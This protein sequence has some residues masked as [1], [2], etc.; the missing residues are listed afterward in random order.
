MTARLLSVNLAVP[1]MLRSPGGRLVPSGIFKVPAD[2]PVA[3]SRES[4]EGDV[5]VDRRYHGGPEQAVYAYASE[6]AAHWSRELETADPLPP[7]FFGENFTTEN[8][9]EDGVAIGDVY[10]VG[11]A[12]VAVTRPRSPCF[13]LGLRVGSP[14][15]LRTFLGSGRLGF[16]L[17]VLEE[18]DVQAGDLIE[19]IGRD[20]R[21]V[22]VSE[23]VR[24]LYSRPVDPAAVQRA[25]RSEA[26]APALRSRLAERLSET[27]PS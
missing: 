10:R 2:G 20:S 4:L 24:L 27:R 14:R 1:G 17:R 26:L 25:L 22:F 11:A 9:L 23:L 15:F 19:R 7:G 18:G 16:Y 8:L 5:Q 12:L 21:L 3:L 13:K 6:H